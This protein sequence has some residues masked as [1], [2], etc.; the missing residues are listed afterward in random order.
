MGHLRFV[1][2]NVPIEHSYSLLIEFK[3]MDNEMLNKWCIY[4]NLLVCDIGAFSLGGKTLMTW[5]EFINTI[6]DT[7]QTHTQQYI[8]PQECT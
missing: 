5:K 3:S 2:E 7:Q 6:N 8:H 1:D 4:L